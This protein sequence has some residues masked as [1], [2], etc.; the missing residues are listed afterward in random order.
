MTPTPI[1]APPGPRRRRAILTTLLTPLAAMLGGCAAF[2]YSE[3]DAPLALPAPPR[4]DPAPRI[5]LVLG[6]GGPRGYAHV[7]VLRVLEEAG[8]EPDLVVGSSVGALIGAFWASGLSATEIDRRSFEGGPLTVFD[9]S[10]FADRGWIHGQKLQ[11][12][13]NR[14]LDGRRIEQLPRRL[15]V[16]ASRR[17]DKAGRFFLS[18]NTGV[19]V[20]ASGAM[21]GIISP[22]G[23]AGVEY[24]DGDEAYPV[25]VS[26]ARSAGAQFIIAVDVSARGGRT[27]AEASAAMRDRDL[28]RRTLIDPEVAQADFLLH[29]DLDY[30]AGPRRSYFIDARVRGE[31][32]ARARLPALQAA[33]GAR[34][35]PSRAA[36]G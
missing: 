32:H 14:G 5:A 17:E 21:P 2:D 9:P 35:G 23:I 31:A 3:P 12:Y 25:P 8:I 7:G 22:V 20:R 27:P 13:V 19:A 1:D 11:D 6:S 15:I 34:F 16:T 36:R 28:R 24:E 33:L 4:L 26:A 18:G 10:P 29:P 30:W